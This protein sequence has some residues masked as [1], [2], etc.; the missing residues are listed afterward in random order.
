MFYDINEQNME[1]KRFYNEHW[2]LCFTYV[3]NIW[4]TFFSRSV[5]SKI[6]HVLLFYV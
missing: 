2:Y 5:L 6:W 4:N 3:C 1:D